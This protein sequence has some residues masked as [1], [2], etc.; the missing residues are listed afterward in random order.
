M[1]STYWIFFVAY[2]AVLV[3]IAVFRARHMDDMSDYVLGGRKIGAFTS[4]ISSGS[5]ATSAGTQL[6]FPALA[7]A[8]GTMHMWTVA[9]VIRG[10][11]AFLDDNG[12]PPAPLHH[13]DR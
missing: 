10:K 9:F 4:A 13:R 6:V 5:L 1:T 12:L 7:F 3:G 2:F 8:A 11:L